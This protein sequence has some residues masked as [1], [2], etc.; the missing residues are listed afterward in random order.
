MN[1]AIRNGKKGI[2]RKV[3]YVKQPVDGKLYK[4]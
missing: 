3:D 4:H 1:Q 2:K